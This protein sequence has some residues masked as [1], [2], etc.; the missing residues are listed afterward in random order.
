MATK[1]I[2]VPQYRQLYET[3][4]KQIT[5][6][7]YHAGDILPS[8]K[9]LFLTHSVTQPTIR[10]ALAMLV[11][12]GY[13]KKHQGKGSIV[14]ELPKGLG[15]LS[16]EGRQP[17]SHSTIKNLTTKIIDGPRL[18]PWADNMKFIPTPDQT[19][20]NFFYIERQRKVEGTVV[21]YEFLYI[22][23]INLPRFATR[24]FENKSLYEILKKFYQIEVKGGEQQIWAIAA[25]APSSNFLEV[26]KGSPVLR[27]ERRIDTNKPGFSIYTSLF[28]NTEKYLLQGII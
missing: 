7:V 13:I 2:K 10:Q 4:R 3:L 1:A 27:L 19:A 22:P 23:N 12:D 14:K 15:I 21:F 25:D 11:N 17:S 18:V 5:G 9:E 6:G 24:N 20:H 26:K 28:V 16:I 8:E